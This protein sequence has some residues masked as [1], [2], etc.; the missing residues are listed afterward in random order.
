MAAD[1]PGARFV[2]VDGV[3]EAPNVQYLDFAVEDASYLA[4]V[5]AA[6]SS[7]TG[8]IAFLGG[9]DVDVIWPYEAGFVAGA[10]A[11]D[12][13]VRILVDYIAEPPN[14]GDGFEDPP[15]ARR[16]AEQLFENGADVL[17]VPAGTA[18]VGAIDAAAASHYAPA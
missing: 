5:A 16:A 2:L 10:R 14:Y 8:T 9:V 18:Q 3:V 12:P 13:G 15:G 7:R 1:Y 17:F 6:R 11:T 4:G